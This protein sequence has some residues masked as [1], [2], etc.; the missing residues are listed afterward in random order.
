MHRMHG[1]S[2][3]AIEEDSDLDLSPPVGEKKGKSRRKRRRAASA[4]PVPKRGSGPP[5]RPGSR[6]GSR[7]ASLAGSLAASRAG[8]V[9]ASRAGSL[10]PSAAGSPLVPQPPKPPQFDPQRRDTVTRG[11]LA[12]PV[13]PALAGLQYGQALPKSLQTAEAGY[14]YGPV[15][16][17]PTAM[18]P[19]A[20]QE[21]QAAV[22]TG[23]MYP[24]PSEFGYM[25]GSMA[26]DGGQW[27][28]YQQDGRK[29]D[30][31]VVREEHVT[32][33]CMLLAALLF[34]VCV[35]GIVVLFSTDVFTIPVWLATEEPTAPEV[36]SLPGGGGGGV[37][38]SV[39]VDQPTT[40]QAT[41]APDTSYQTANASDPRYTDRYHRTACV[42]HASAAGLEPVS[43][44]VRY[45]LS[46]FPFALCR[47]ALFCCPSLAADVEPGA[48]HPDA[49]MAEFASRA[50][51]S[52]FVEPLMMLGDGAQ[53]SHAS[54]EQLLD[55]L[56]AGSLPNTVG[57]WY[58]M[59]NYAGVVL[60]FPEVVPADTSLR[61]P[62]LLGQLAQKLAA[63][64]GRNVRLGVALRQDAQGADLRGLAA[65]L[66]PVSV[67]LLPPAMTLGRYIGNTF[68]YFSESTLVTLSQLYSAHFGPDHGQSVCYLLPADTYTFQILPSSSQAPMPAQRSI[69]PGIQGPATRQRGRMAYFESCRVVADQSYATLGLPYGVVASRGDSWLSY[70]EPQ[71]LGR[72]ADALHDNAS[73]A[74]VGLWRPQ[75]DDFASLC[76]H[77]AYPL[78]RAL[79]RHYADVHP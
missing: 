76:G 44:G 32:V 26:A 4:V 56:E 53:S 40:R 71:L 3:C 5:V 10:A 58:K 17:F 1:C 27:P 78:A 65:A 69:G 2:I 16:R 43:S 47:V 21:P 50:L 48:E 73:A 20:C 22:A 64:P 18:W 38:I 11:S 67:F 62:R 45:G 6:S 33:P 15:H 70:T 30:S 52:G 7:A 9:A 46:L 37:S 54:F 24:F 57:S 74:C 49:T 51:R 12:M 66:G 13:Q 35:A 25:D 29:A 68:S 39:Y 75:W 63:S 23:E 36:D 60:R 59:R 72:F 41:L 28:P 31:P 34:V 77:G 79:F 42:F 14:Q 19:P 8:S 61:V 55:D